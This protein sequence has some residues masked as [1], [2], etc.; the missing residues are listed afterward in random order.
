MLADILPTGV[1]A[2]LQALN[3]PKVLPVI[4]GKP[5]PSS[6]FPD[7]VTKSTETS[8]T[9]ED[10]VLTLAVVGLGPVGLCTCVSLLDM[11]AARQVSFQVVAIDPVED[12]R[13]KMKAVYAKIDEQGKG[14][15]KFVVQDIETAKE[16]VKEWTSGVGCTAV[17]EVSTI[18]RVANICADKGSYIDCR[19]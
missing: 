12:R 9:P 18:V 11:L 7:E 8:L 10:K 14:A 15:G 4:T 5:W 6:F 3:H 19:K 16:T 1:F 17:L 2:A 13:E